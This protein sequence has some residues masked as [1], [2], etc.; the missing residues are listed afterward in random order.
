MS[1]RAA[2]CKLRAIQALRN[3]DARRASKLNAL[4]EALQK[5]RNEARAKN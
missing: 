3:N 1:L 4:L 5:V 2:T